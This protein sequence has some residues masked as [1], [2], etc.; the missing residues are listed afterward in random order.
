MK[1]ELVEVEDLKHIESY[2]KRRVEWL[3]EKIL[4]EQIW[5]KP[6]ALDTQHA[7]VMDGQH[8]ME[9]AR[10]LKLKRVPAIKFTYADVEIWS[11]RPGKYEFDWKM[12]T[13]RALSGDIYPYKTVKHR[14]PIDLPVISYSLDELR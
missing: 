8:R 9:V 14:F 4:N 2:S 1:V 12:I 13:E 10:A 7:L 11:L 6:L 5:N 3:K